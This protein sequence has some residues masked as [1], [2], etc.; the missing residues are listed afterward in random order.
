M[1]TTT[2]QV[3]NGKDQPVFSLQSID[4]NPNIQ[5][6]PGL[7]AEALGITIEVVGDLRPSRDGMGV[8][9]TISFQ[10]SGNLPLP[11]RILPEGVLKGA[12]E[13]INQIVVNFAV[14]S[15]QKGAVAKYQ[16]FQQQQQRTTQVQVQAQ[17]E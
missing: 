15:F 5:L 17:Q 6:L 4:Y 13:A 14:A 9:G 16:E 12:S 3:Q 8:V 2:T 1:W 10:S 7:G 11:M